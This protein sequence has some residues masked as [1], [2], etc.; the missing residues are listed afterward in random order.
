MCPQYGIPE[1]LRKTLGHQQTSCDDNQWRRWD[2]ELVEDGPLDLMTEVGEG[3]VIAGLGDPEMT[4]TEILT[5]NLKPLESV[6]VYYYDKESISGLAELQSAVVTAATDPL[7]ASRGIIGY[8]PNVQPFLGYVLYL[9]A[10]IPVFTIATS[11]FLYQVQLWTVFIGLGVG[12]FN[13][14][15]VFPLD[16]FG[17]LNALMERGGVTGSRNKAVLYSLMAFSLGLLVLNLGAAYLR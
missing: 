4:V 14:L 16:G 13:M 1:E 11:T 2:E 10:R 17:F 5:V 9:P 15:P 7:N 12:I 8:F 6:T 3:D